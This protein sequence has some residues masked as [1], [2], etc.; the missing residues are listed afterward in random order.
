MA[1]AELDKL[2]VEEYFS[3]IESHERKIR[4]MQKAKK[5]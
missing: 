3:L 1:M 4:A 2:S 5:S